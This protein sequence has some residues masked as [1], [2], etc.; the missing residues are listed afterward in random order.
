MTNQAYSQV[1]FAT[2]YLTQIYYLRQLY[3]L[4]QI[5]S[6]VS[7]RCALTAVTSPRIEILITF[8][9][10][11]SLHN[12]FHYQQ[13]EQNFKIYY[14]ELLMKDHKP[15]GPCFPSSSSSGF[16]PERPGTHSN[17]RYDDSPTSTLGESFSNLQCY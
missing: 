12:L 16:S 9:T 15:V 17:V 13:F 10:Q 2:C 1:E 7:N 6:S 14:K 4:Y 5:L 8:N 11:Y 3:Q